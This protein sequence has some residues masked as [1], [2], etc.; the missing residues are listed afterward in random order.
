[1]FLFPKFGVLIGV[2]RCAVLLSYILNTDFSFITFFLKTHSIV[3]C[4]SWEEPKLGHKVLSSI[5]N[6]M[7][8]KPACSYVVVFIYS[9]NIGGR[10]IVSFSIP[11][12]QIVLVKEKLIIYNADEQ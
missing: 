3:G 6:R 12:L 2:W 7:G 9:V 5:I 8:K 11:A 4:L 1:M 10:P